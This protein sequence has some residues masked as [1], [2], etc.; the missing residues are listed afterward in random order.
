LPDAALRTPGNLYRIQAWGRDQGFAPP[1]NTSLS[2][3]LQV[4]IGP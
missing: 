4:P 3:A 1:N 2:N